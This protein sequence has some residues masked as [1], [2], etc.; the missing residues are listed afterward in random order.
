MRTKITWFSKHG[1]IL[2]SLWDK[3]KK[4]LEMAIARSMVDQQRLEAQKKSQSDMMENE[5]KKLSLVKATE[6]KT[7]PPLA[8][9]RGNLLTF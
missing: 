7:F 1:K 9:T 4:E 3:E 6:G 5:M 2:K 8:M